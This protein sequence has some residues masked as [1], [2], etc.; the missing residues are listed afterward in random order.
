MYHGASGFK[1]SDMTLACSR[2]FHFLPPVM[3]GCY[4]PMFLASW[5][6]P[7][8]PRPMSRPQSWPAF[9]GLSNA[10]PTTYI[11]YRYQAVGVLIAH[12]P[13]L[14]RFAA[15]CVGYRSLFSEE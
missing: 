9:C 5:I 8:F 7:M 6:W 15:A 11:H 4:G 1:G 13:E 12:P 10:A 3:A 14:Q 2:H